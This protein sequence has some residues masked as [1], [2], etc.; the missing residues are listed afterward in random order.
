MRRPGPRQTS[1][2]TGKIA[3]LWERFPEG[4]H[5]GT[6]LDL[7]AGYG[8]IDLH[9]ARAKGLTCDTFYALDISETMLRRL[10]EYREQHSVF[11]DADVVAICASADDIPLDDASV[12]LVLS[13]A[14]FLHMGKGFVART[15]SEL[16]R[17]LK[18][19]G[20]FVF[21]VAFPNRAEPVELAAAPE[22]PAAAQPERAQVLDAPG[23]RAAPARDGPCRR[24]PAARSSSPAPTPRC[25]S[26]SGRC[27]SRGAA[28]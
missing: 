13:S 3:P 7:G 1:C 21:D 14:V 27:R 15:V 20:A 11:P 8:R 28:R 10:L 12:D 24:A 23:D 25:R 2:L 16:A 18:P 5:V 6:L 4:L 9:L 26:A 22:A 17:V 19:G